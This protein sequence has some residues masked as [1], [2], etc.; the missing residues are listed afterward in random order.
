[1]YSWLI[2]NKYFVS[3][4]FNTIKDLLLNSAKENNI[5][6]DVFNNIEII[7][8]LSSN[9]FKKPD[10]FRDTIIFGMERE[11]YEESN[12]NH[13]VSRET[14]MK[15]METRI[16]G[17]FRWLKK[18]G[19]A[20]FVGLSRINENYELSPDTSEVFQN[21][22]PVL[23]N[24]QTI[25]LLKKSIEKYIKKTDE[26]TYETSNVSVSCTMALLALH[27]E[28]MR[29]CESCNKKGDQ[30]CTNCPENPYYVLF[31]E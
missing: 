26:Y 23:I 16:T 22:R 18:A 8:I 2:T 3:N 13:D 9:N 29:Y 27:R 4:N 25:D 14:F 19:K 15:D 10:G 7:D 11:A 6:M 20:E 5:M 30:N 21:K 17:Y 24:A 31:H 12:G 1:M 28:C